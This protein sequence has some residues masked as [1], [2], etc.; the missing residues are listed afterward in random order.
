MENL[1][2]QQI[3]ET[4][5]FKSLSMSELELNPKN[6]RTADKKQMAQLVDSINSVGV[7]LPFTVKKGEN[8][9]YIIL[10]GN[11]RYQACLLAKYEKPIDCRVIPNDLDEKFEYEL[12]LE[13]NKMYAENDSA[14]LKA[15]FAKHTEFMR[16]EFLERIAG[17][18]VKIEDIVKKKP[19]IEMDNANRE[20]MDRLLAL[21]ASLEVIL[22][23]TE[24]QQDSNYLVF[25]YQKNKYVVLNCTADE[26][27]QLYEIRKAEPEHFKD[28]VLSA[29][30]NAF[31]AEK[32][33]G[34]KKK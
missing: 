3:M 26:V 23:E 6:P 9:K 19:E 10:D 4:V 22:A 33:D 18:K 12:I 34:K 20:R 30:F 17:A 14:R 2:L 28:F 25:T 5:E 27:D 21:K 16:P 13:I 15:I 24:E 8:G 7:L 29:I 1:S 32:L 11:H 31:N